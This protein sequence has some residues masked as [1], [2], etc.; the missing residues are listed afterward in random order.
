MRKDSLQMD[1][2]E[3]PQYTSEQAHRLIDRSE[4]PPDPEN[5]RIPFRTQPRALTQNEV[6]NFRSKHAS[7][8]V[9][10][11]WLKDIDKV[12]Q[13][14]RTVNNL[15]DSSLEALLRHPDERVRIALVQNEARDTGWGKK[16][17]AMDA[18]LR[19]YMQALEEAD[20]E[21]VVWTPLLDAIASRRFSPSIFTYR[22]GADG[23]TVSIESPERR[24]ERLIPWI[25][26]QTDPSAF[27]PLWS[28]EYSH[29]RRCIVRHAKCLTNDWVQRVLQGEAEVWHLAR[30]PT[31]TEQQRQKIH[32][33]ALACFKGAQKYGVFYQTHLGLHAK[34]TLIALQ[35]TGWPVPQSTREVLL[36]IANTKINN[37]TWRPTSVDAQRSLS[38]AL[39]LRGAAMETLLEL[40]D[41]STQHLIRLFDAIQDGISGYQLNRFLQHPAADLNFLRHI[42]R[43]ASRLQGTV[44]QVLAEKAEARHDPV[45]RE[46]LTKSTSPTLHVALCQDATNPETFSK[47]FRKILRNSPEKALAV[48]MTISNSSELVRIDDVR[49]FVEGPTGKSKKDKQPTDWQRLDVLIWLRHRPLVGDPDGRPGELAENYA[50]QYLPIVFRRLIEGDTAEPRKLVYLLRKK[51]D[52]IVD[53]LDKEDLLPLLQSP[54]QELRLATMLAISQLTHR[55][56]PAARAEVDTPVKTR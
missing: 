55:A 11:K 46:I 4:P 25:Q 49:A 2:F 26:S 54:N 20:A 32:D 1:L 35:E 42:A 16:K 22:S 12:I 18:K 7:S 36:N 31:L 39:Y 52:K 21:E 45:I 10:P 23:R 33:W 9:P 13:F 53:L 51:G 29:V 44:R 48:L 19:L 40:K 37:G 38:D 50:R 6:H 34:W 28:F 27:D 8:P 43:H 56:Q 5:R 41:L 47:H 24:V 14:A 15:S 17:R 3:F 30:N